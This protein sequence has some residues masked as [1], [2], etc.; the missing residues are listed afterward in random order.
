M[1]KLLPLLTAV[2]VLTA[3]GASAKSAQHHSTAKENHSFTRAYGMAGCGLGSMLMGKKGG[4]LSAATTNGTLYNQL[5]GI[6]FNTLN[7]DDSPSN[8]VAQR[9]D[10]FVAANQVA[11]ASDA[12]RGS[13]ETLSHLSAMLGCDTQTDQVGTVMQRN[14]SQ[15]FPDTSVQPNQVTD[16]IITA[17]M[18]DQSLSGACK[19]IVG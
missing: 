2:L 13:G 5:F 16:S 11:I 6:T 9:M 18:K 14:F 12:A 7:C 3:Q 19:N 17:I 10:K 15:I 4:Q 8:E 1:K